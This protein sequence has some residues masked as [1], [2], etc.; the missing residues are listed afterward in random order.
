MKTRKEIWNGEPDNTPHLAST[1]GIGGGVMV[2]RVTLSEEGEHCEQLTR[3]ERQTQDNGE[4][5]GG[6]EDQKRGAC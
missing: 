6:D 5:E 1:W 4:P 3:S 2:R